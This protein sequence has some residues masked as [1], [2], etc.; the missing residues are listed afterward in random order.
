MPG[1]Y[2]RQWEPMT[3]AER[4]DLH[5]RYRDDEGAEVW[6]NNRYQCIVYNRVGRSG[7]EVKQLSIHLHDRSPARNWR[8]LQQIKN[9]CCGEFWTGIEIFPPENELTD[10]ANEYHMFCF[11]PEVNLGISL[12]EEAV[13]TD[14]DLAEQY[15][16]DSAHK[17][18]QEPWED[19][20]TTGRTEASADSRVRAREF[21]GTHYGYGK[22]RKE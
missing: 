6:T 16:E 13:V 15:T 4:E 1:G 22:E 21:A 2:I 17:G 19:G 14:D 18:K 10:S 7:N 12:G 20:L 9:E 5:E 3:K 11:P 8:H